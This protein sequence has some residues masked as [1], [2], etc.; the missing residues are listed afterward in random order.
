MFAEYQKQVLLTY[1]RKKDEN[2]KL[3]HYL[4]HVTAANLR[5][6][7]IETITKRFSQRDQR[8]LSAFFEHHENEEGYLQALYNIDPDIFKPLNNFLKG[9]TSHTSSKNVELLAWLIDFQPRPW[10]WDHDYTKSGYTETLPDMDDGVQGTKSKMPQMKTGKSESMVSSELEKVE[11]QEKKQQLSFHGQKRT[12]DNRLIFVVVGI[13]LLL[14][15]GGAYYLSADRTD[16]HE[17]CMCWMGDHYQR[18]SCNQNQRENAVYAL[19]SIKM[20]RFRKITR[21]DTITAASVGHI[22]YSK[23]DGKVE[24]YTDNGFHPVHTERKLKPLTAYMLNKYH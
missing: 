5:L 18:V 22:W 23:I 3:S 12:I 24:Y 14:I 11:E 6:A 10:Q 7:C 20:E 2:D 13:V 9:N 16:V 15:G 4:V 1:H 8:I 21:P 17:R 19:D